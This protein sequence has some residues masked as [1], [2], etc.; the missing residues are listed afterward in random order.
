M[1]SPKIHVPNHQPD[2]IHSNSGNP[3]TKWDLISCGLKPIKG[4][5]NKPVVPV[6][7]KKSLV[8]V[9]PPQNMVDPRGKFM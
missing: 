6:N 2:Q 9:H 1:E 8:V 4:H 7:S 3:F 5:M